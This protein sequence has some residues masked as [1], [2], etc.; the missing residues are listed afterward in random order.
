M[1][2]WHDA[3][4]SRNMSI[5]ELPSNL[6]LVIQRQNSLL[7]KLLF[8][9]WKAHIPSFLHSNIT[10][11]DNVSNPLP[12]NETT[13]SLFGTHPTP[14]TLHA[15]QYG[16]EAVGTRAERTTESTDGQN[17]V[18]NRKGLPRVAATS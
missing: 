12:S 13:F 7:E 18:S 15:R 4:D 5:F 6:Y 3:V 17:P 10:Q 2:A 1:Y 14:P 9:A 16:F 8:F 11:G